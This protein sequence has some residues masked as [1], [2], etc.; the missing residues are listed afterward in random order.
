MSFVERFIALSPYLGESTIRGSSVYLLTWLT[1]LSAKILQ[2]H[3]C[4]R[5]HSVCVYVCVCVLCV[6]VCV[7]LCVCVCVCVCVC[8]LVCM[9]AC[10]HACLCICMRACMVLNISV[11]M[12]VGNS[13]CVYI[14]VKMRMVWFS[15]VIISEMCLLS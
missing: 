12:S 7:C 10:V 1:H 15:R 11:Q 9:F 6:C 3:D 4:T 5:I 2:K 8:M 13:M 14:L